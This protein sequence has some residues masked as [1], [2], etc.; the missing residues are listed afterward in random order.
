MNP[1][2]ELKA[3][4][5][6]T[7]VLQLQILSPEKY[8]NGIDRNQKILLEILNPDELESIINIYENQIN[9][10]ILARKT[11]LISERLQ[12]DHYCNN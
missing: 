6:Y 5:I 8:K 9:S 4:L 12:S 10:L 7:I 1:K 2:D 3:V 11:K